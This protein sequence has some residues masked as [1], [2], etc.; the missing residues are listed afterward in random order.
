MK[1]MRRQMQ[2]WRVPQGLEFIL[3]V[4]MNESTNGRVDFTRNG[5]YINYYHQAHLTWNYFWLETPCSFFLLVY[6]SFPRI[7]I[8]RHGYA[9]TLG[10]FKNRVVFFGARVWL[11]WWWWWNFY[12]LLEKKAWNKRGKSL[13]KNWINVDL[14]CG[15]EGGKR[16]IT[17]LLGQMHRTDKFRIR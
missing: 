2:K 8:R 9:Y 12:F 7:Y 4:T 16:K 1:M 3:L 10:P 14:S 5:Y 6:K 11:L 13:K 17:P 15:Q